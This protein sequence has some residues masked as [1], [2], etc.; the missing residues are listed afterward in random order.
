M[1]SSVTEATLLASHQDQR[2]YLEGWIIIKCGL[3]ICCCSWPQQRAHILIKKK[4]KRTN[5]FRQDM[6]CKGQ[7]KEAVGLSKIICSESCRCQGWV[8]SQVTQV[9]G[10]GLGRHCV[11][12]SDLRM[13]SLLPREECL[14]G[15]P[16]LE[17]TC[18]ATQLL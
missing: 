11:F 8:P 17:L 18:T 16:A 15:V 10:R 2:L 13:D 14:L 9:V 4:K 5:I 3:P 12:C 7:L 6:D 1:V